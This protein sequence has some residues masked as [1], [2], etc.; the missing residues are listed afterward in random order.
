MLRWWQERAVHGLSWNMVNQWN[1]WTNKKSRQPMESWAAQYC[2]L[3]LSFI[4]QPGFVILKGQNV[5]VCLFFDSQQLTLSH[6]FCGWRSSGERSGQS[7]QAVPP[8]LSFICGILM[9]ILSVSFHLGKLAD[10]PAACKPKWESQRCCW[11]KWCWCSAFQRA[12]AGSSVQ[13]ENHEA[14]VSQ[15]F[16]TMCAQ[17]QTGSF[18]IEHLLDL[19]VQPV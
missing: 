10:L 18:G 8:G 1:W 14:R 15:H 12:S 11:W 17:K 16:R 3:S 4:D 13:L 19:H 2:T 7:L 9:H 5:E 6:C